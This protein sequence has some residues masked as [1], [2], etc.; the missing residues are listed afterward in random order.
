VWEVVIGVEPSRPG[1][2]PPV[3]DEDPWWAP[4]GATAQAHGC[5]C[6]VLANA[7]YRRGQQSAPMVDPGC[8][9][10]AMPHAG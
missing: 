10:H 3:K 2:E 1:D 5:V 9:L 7:A 4:G 8:R 6:S